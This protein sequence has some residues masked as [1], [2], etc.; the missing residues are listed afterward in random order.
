MY[1]YMYSYIYLFII[2]SNWV[3]EYIF[4]YE[5]ILWYVDYNRRKLYFYC[6]DY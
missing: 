3:I 6:F 5:N 1:V 2:E 4:F